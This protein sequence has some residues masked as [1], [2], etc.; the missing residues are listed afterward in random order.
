V[1]TVGAGVGI[2][3]SVQ[4]ADFTLGLQPIGNAVPVGACVC[5]KIGWMSEVAS[6]GHESCVNPLQA[7]EF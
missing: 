6:G 3:G 4:P 5:G 7:V 1:L 2:S